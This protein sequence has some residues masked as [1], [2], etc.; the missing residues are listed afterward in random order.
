MI[1]SR[2]STRGWYTTAS[3]RMV[4]SHELT[5]LTFSMPPQ[6]LRGSAVREAGLAILYPWPTPTRLIE[7]LAKYMHARLHVCITVTWG[8]N[9]QH[10]GS[11]HVNRR[12]RHTAEC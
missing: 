6:Q 12:S 3:W 9:A 1:W 4:F 8:S 11:M 10:I 7:D 2:V 5:E